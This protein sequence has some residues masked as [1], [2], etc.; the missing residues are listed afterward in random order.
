M[1]TI[2]KRGKKKILKKYLS[3]SFFL[4]KVFF[5]TKQN[6]KEKKSQVSRKQSFRMQNIRQS[7]KPMKTY[8]F[9][10]LP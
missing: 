2:S 4:K 1:L 7:E 9:E 3:F 6:I 8:Y 10:L 5:S